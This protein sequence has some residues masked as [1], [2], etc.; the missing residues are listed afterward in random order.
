MSFYLAW[1]IFNCFHGQI[2]VIWALSMCCYWQISD[3]RRER[4]R[5]AMMQE[6]LK[7]LWRLVSSTT[8]SRL[9]ACLELCITFE[10]ICIRPN[11]WRHISLNKEPCAHY[12]LVLLFSLS[13]SRNLIKLLVFL[14]MSRKSILVNGRYYIQGHFSLNVQF[15][16]LSAI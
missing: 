4:K 12:L 2:G 9:I 11:H 16:Q 10:C 13:I 8:E 1:F 6:A 3:Y 5:R 15:W 7:G 14:S